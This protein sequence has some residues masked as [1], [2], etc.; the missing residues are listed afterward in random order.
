[1]FYY[2]FGVT[3]IIS[4]NPMHVLYKFYGEILSLLKIKDFF[5]AN[6]I[7]RGEHNTL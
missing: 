7:E 2:G 4:T 5:I 1:M 3:F 6:V